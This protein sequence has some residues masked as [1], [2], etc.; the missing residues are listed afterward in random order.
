VRA[1]V[2]LMPIYAIHSPPLVGDV[3]VA[4]DR[5][6][7]LETGF[8]RRAF[9]F[10]PLWLLAHRLWVPLGA[11]VALAVALGVAQ[12]FGWLAPPGASFVYLLSALW[13]GLEGRDWLGAK[14]ADAGAPLVDVV[15]ARDEEEAA[16]VFLGRAPSPPPPKT[17]YMGAERAGPVIGQ[18]PGG[19]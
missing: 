10:G 18:F 13:I 8:C 5:A 7:L 19:V 15:E 17:R 6:R 9:V 4:F 11:W 16:R 3:A 2:S 1:N 14:L 12:G